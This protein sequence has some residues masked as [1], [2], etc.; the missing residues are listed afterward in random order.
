[1]NLGPYEFRHW[2]P[3]EEG[4]ILQLKFPPFATFL[5]E[6][7]GESV[8]FGFLTKADGPREWCPTPE[9]PPPAAFRPLR[10]IAP[11]QLV[12]LIL[13][14]ETPREIVHA[15]DESFW[16]IPGV[17]GFLGEP[18]FSRFPKNGNLMDFYAVR[19]MRTVYK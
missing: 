8:L 13:M 7:S 3:F 19:S 5:H 4:A 17:L 12:S 9:P 11:R 2:V 14:R 1:M 18:Y 15:E 10:F 16:E 6:R